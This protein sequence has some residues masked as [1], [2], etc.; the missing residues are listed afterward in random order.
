MLPYAG[1]ILVMTFLSLNDRIRRISISNVDGRQVSMSPTCKYRFHHVWVRL[2]SS[3]RKKPLFSKRHFYTFG[4]VLEI[5]E[6]SILL[7]VQLIIFL[8][9]SAWKWSTIYQLAKN[10]QY[11]CIFLK[12]LN[13]TDSQYV[14]FFSGVQNWDF[15]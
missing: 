15:F 14:A 10:S 7:D 1:K 5:T 8:I 2:G 4:V 12:F 3:N 11:V 13:I 6:F 9:F